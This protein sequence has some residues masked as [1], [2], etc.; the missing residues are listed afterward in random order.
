LVYGFTPGFP[1]KIEYFD[2]LTDAVETAQEWS[3]HLEFVDDA[4]ESMPAR[5]VGI[6]E[7]LEVVKGQPASAPRHSHTETQR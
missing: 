2:R 6:C 5:H 4:F 3:D 7:L 1:A